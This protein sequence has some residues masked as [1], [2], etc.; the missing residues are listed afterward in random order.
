MKEG[1]RSDNKNAQYGKQLE[2]FCSRDLT[3]GSFRKKTGS[4]FALWCGPPAEGLDGGAVG[5]GAAA[6]VGDGEG[7]V[8]DH[9]AH[10]RALE[11]Q[12]RLRGTGGERGKQWR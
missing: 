8:Q 5:G 9:G 6:E 3:C 12:R 10:C 1:T 4:F 7:G 11:P 2:H